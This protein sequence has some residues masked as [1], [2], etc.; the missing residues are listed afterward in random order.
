MSCYL[1]YGPFKNQLRFM[2]GRS[3]GD[4]LTYTSYEDI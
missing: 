4:P 1:H 2:L 3:F